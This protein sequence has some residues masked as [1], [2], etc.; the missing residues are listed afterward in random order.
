MSVSTFAYTDNQEPGKTWDFIYI[1][2]PFIKSDFD[3]PRIKDALQ[4]VLDTN[5]QA[6]VLDGIND[7]SDLLLEDKWRQYELLKDLMPETQPL[8][9][10]PDADLNGWLIK[11]RISGRSRDIHFNA[12]ELGQDID[13]RDY[14]TQKRLDIET[15]IRAFMIGGKPELPL[16]IKASK[17]P[18]GKTKVIG[19][20]TDVPPEVLEICAQVASRLR[21]DFMGLDI[22]Q[23]PK[24]FFLIE[25]NRSPQFRSYYQSNSINLAEKLIEHLIEKNK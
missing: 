12:S 21:F 18:T 9:T 16:E 1:R 17:S 24:G 10:L 3:D 19:M 4:K 25:V 11:K 22:A 2:G 5:R 20:K 8:K 7:F 13:P 6:Y 23:T 14:I 15:E